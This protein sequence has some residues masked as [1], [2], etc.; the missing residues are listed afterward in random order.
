[1]IT[2]LEKEEDKRQGIEAGVSA[3][4]VKGSFDQSNLLDA[5]ERLIG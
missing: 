4:I 1:M 2:A 5:I 3:Y